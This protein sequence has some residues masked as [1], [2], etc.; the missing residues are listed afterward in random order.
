MKIGIDISQ[1][2]YGT[3]VSWYT[4]NL[5]K[6]LISAGSGNQFV[7]FGGGVRKLFSLSEYMSQFPPR[8]TRKLFPISPLVA[9]FLWNKLH[10]FPIEGLIGKIDV[11]HS[12][13][14][15][16]P[17]CRAFK[18]T[19]VHDMSPFKYPQL[20]PS[21]IVQVHTRKMQWVKRE[22][23]R[24]IAVSQST[25]QDLV[26]Y[27]IPG[28]K[29]RVIPEAPDPIFTFQSREN[30][31][32]VLSKYHI[33]S[34]Y[35][36]AVGLHPRKN[37]KRI[38]KAY[39]R[40]GIKRELK[41][42]FIGKSANVSI[43]D[44][45]VY[46]GQVPAADMPALYSGALALV[47]PSLYEGFGLPILEAFACHCPVVTSNISSM[48][49]IGGN[50]VV[51]VDPQS[52]ESI[53]QGIKLAIRMRDSLV[54]KGARRVREFTWNKAARATLDVYKEALSGK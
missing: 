54:L 8:V 29:I 31:T 35:L 4:E 17:P 19:T 39:Q 45:V 33:D 32:S 2:V 3:G 34:K 41:L 42:V 44:G 30:I 9:D 27:G 22:V 14:W 11:F 26:E 38:V 53:V 28:E 49:E 36:L 46:L 25:K 48:P 24:I 7:L 43:H 6:S 15:T 13:D 18:V 50:A 12:S 52:L 1:V 16:Q 47:Y 40:L 51:Y 10:R 23:D 20:T 21:S 5:V 37:S